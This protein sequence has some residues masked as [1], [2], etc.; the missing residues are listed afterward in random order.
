MGLVVLVVLF[1]LGA[2]Q[3]GCVMRWRDYRMGCLERKR[4][5]RVYIPCLSLGFQ[6]C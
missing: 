1:V 5:K 2:K 6:L 4:I 3:C